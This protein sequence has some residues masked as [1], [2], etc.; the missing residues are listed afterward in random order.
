MLLDK[1]LRIVRRNIT[2]P[3]KQ[4]TVEIS[5]FYFS[6]LVGI[7]EEYMGVSRDIIWGGPEL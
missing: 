7:H 5:I 4:Q 1:I 3:Y 2:P 6:T